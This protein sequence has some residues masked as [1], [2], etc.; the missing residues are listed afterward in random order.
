MADDM[1]NE[2][3]ARLFAPPRNRHLKSGL[4]ELNDVFVRRKEFLIHENAGQ[5]SDEHPNGRATV[6]MCEQIPAA[7]GLNELGTQLT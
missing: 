2:F 7:I 6:R 4:S 1:A 5:D 3:I